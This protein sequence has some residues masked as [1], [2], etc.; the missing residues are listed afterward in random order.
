ML[1]PLFLLFSSACT[2]HSIPLPPIVSDSTPRIA[3]H[4]RVIGRKDEPKWSIS[5]YALKIEL[6]NTEDSSITLTLMNCSW[7]DSFLTDRDSVN[8]LGAECDKN[9][10]ESIQ[11]K[12]HQSIQYIGQIKRHMHNEFKS[13]PIRLKIGFV[14]LHYHQLGYLFQATRANLLQYKI[15]WS[16]SIELNPESP[17]QQ[18]NAA[19]Q[20]IEAHQ[21]TKEKPRK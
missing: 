8:L 3:V 17:D 2:A 9:F 18:D 1:I 10:P 7:Q 5:Y 6:E 13:S 4:V 14:D 11:I 16:N 19:P 21:G 12:P 15:Y 20:K